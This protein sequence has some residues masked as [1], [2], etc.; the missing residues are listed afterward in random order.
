LPQYRILGCDNVY[1]G[2]YVAEVSQDSDNSNMLM[3]ATEKYFSKM[4]SLYH[5]K[6]QARSTFHVMQVTTEKLGL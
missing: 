2:K 6:G 3:V 1:F 4:P 5:K